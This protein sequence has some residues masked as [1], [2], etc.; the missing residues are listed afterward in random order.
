MT[1]ADLKKRTKQFSI[2][3]IKFVSSLPHGEVKSVLGRQLM[4]SATSV[5][6]NYRSACRGRS[7]AEFIAKLGI[8]EEEADESMLWLELFMET[9]FADNVNAKKLWKEADELTAIFTSSIITSRK[10]GPIQNQ[11]SKIKNSVG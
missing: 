4:R 2:D 10:S 11:Q 5:A 1:E 7:K 3:V 9:G 6:A 8:C